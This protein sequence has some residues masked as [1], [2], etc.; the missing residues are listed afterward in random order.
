MY[1]VSDAFHEAVSNGNRQMPLLIFED[2]VFT[3]EDIKVDSGID[4][5]DYCNTETDIAIGG[6]PSNELS[7]TLFN[8]DRLLNDY[9]FGEFLATI[10]VL[11]EENTYKQRGFVTVTTGQAQYVGSSETPYL[12]RGGTAVSSQ[13]TFPV[14]SILAYDGKVYCFGNEGEYAV[15]NDSTG[16]NITAQ[17]SLNAFM[18]RK[19]AGWSGKGIYY[20]KKT[21][22]LFIYEGGTRQ[23]YE[24]CP[25]GVFTA[26]RPNVPDKIEIDFTCYDRMQNFEQDMPTASELGM[27]YPNTIGGLY[28]KLCQYAEVPTKVTDFINSDADI[29]TEPTEF[30]SVTMRTVLGWIAEAAC[31]NAKV[32]RDGFMCLKWL[33]STSQTFD[34]SGYSSFETYWYETKQID[35]LYNRDTSNVTD[36]VIGSGDNAYLIQDNPLLAGAVE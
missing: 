19:G 32:D 28:F 13:P 21:R 2:C 7:L 4:F 8:D 36:T 25:L 5:Q 11:L 9:T 24:F 17:N 1:P 22:I 3:S 16:A 14:Q 12:T 18:Q 23:R 6:T 31:A 30:E 26:E 15:Y 29:T 33:E 27:T 34:E 35:K 10:G 20:N